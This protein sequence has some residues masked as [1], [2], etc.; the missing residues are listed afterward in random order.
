[1][2]TNSNLF[3]LILLGLYCSGCYRDSKKETSS[4]LDIIP[5]NESNLDTILKNEAKEVVIKNNSVD[6]Q[7][8]PLDSSYDFYSKVEYLVISRKNRPLIDRLEMFP[9]LVGLDLAGQGIE[10]LPKAMSKLTKL[11]IIIAHRNALT[12]IPD[13]ICGLKK[14]REVDFESN[15]LKYF[16]DCFTELQQIEILFFSD[17]M[18]QHLPEK[19]G[20]FSNLRK[21]QANSNMIKKLPNE[22]YGLSNLEYCFLE[23]NSQL[24]FELKKSS[25]LKNLEVLALTCSNLTEVNIEYLPYLRKLYLPNASAELREKLDSIKIQRPEISIFP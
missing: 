2:L 13:W 3:L 4:N 9:N 10:V 17:N 21:I 24:D 8:A 22:F 12:E 6:W 11:E 1:M 5:K 14:L 18:I 25:N 23:G 20:S 7:I 19:I 15:K 16:P